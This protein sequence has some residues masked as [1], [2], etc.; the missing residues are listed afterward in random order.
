I[1]LQRGNKDVTSH[2]MELTLR[3]KRGQETMKH[4]LRDVMV[5]VHAC[6]PCFSL[7]LAETKT[8]LGDKMEALD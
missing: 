8:M 1:E 4:V 7:K 6:M 3:D 5:Q 2:F